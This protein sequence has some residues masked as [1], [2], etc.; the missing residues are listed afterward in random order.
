MKTIRL[1]N[2]AERDAEPMWS[3]GYRFQTGA[4]YGG[5]E[6]FPGEGLGNILTE[7][8]WILTDNNKEREPVMI[9]TSGEFNEV[10]MKRV[11]TVF[12]TY[13]KAEQTVVTYA[14]NID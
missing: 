3:V 12:D 6:A 9:L 4:G 11:K 10:D 13:S 2:H 8:L 7:S 1:R 14:K 5:R